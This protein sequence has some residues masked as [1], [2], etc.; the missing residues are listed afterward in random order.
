MGSF[1]DGRAAGFE[2]SSGPAAVL[3]LG[4]ANPL[5]AVNQST[6][7]DFYFKI[8][9][10]EHKSDLKATFT[11]MCKT[12]GPPL[13][14]FSSSSSPPP[15]K[16]NR[17]I[18]YFKKICNIPKLDEKRHFHLTEE[19][20]ELLRENPGIC[21]YDAPSLDTRM[22]MMD[23]DIPKLGYEA[24]M[25]AIEEWGWPNREITHLIV[26]NSG[27]GARPGPDVDLLKMLGLSWTTKRFMLYQIGCHAGATAHRPPPRQ[28]RGREQPGS[29]G[30]GR[31]LRVLLGR[32][33]WALRDPPRERRRPCLVRRRRRRRH[34][35]RRPG[36]RRGA[37][38][39]PT[40]PGGS[41]REGDEGQVRR[42]TYYWPYGVIGRGRLELCFYVCH[43]GGRTILDEI[44]RKLGLAPERLEVSREVLRR[45]GNMM[46]ACVFVVMDL[47]RKRSVKEGR[48]TLGEDLDWG[49]LVAFGPGLT[50]ESLVL[51]AAPRSFP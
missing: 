24:A 17:S 51:R 19:V 10:C 16:I 47:M 33:P 28:G 45:Y 8:T 15:A 49:V 36:G 46:S 30:P 35:G 1:A 29:P 40:R 48:R 50:V 34:R 14:Y 37:S 23:V 12:G 6:Y 3:A 39:L 4:T 18:E 25:K 44:D 31:Q 7:P 9:N 21:G 13:V 27:G 5:V 38:P 20:L 32:L 42:V 41:H 22:V 11:R 26:C 2:R 43:P